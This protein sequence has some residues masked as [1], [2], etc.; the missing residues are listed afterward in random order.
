MNST[1]NKREREELGV[2]DIVGRFLTNFKKP[3]KHTE[4]KTKDKGD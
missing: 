3:R 1:R 4:M 2:S